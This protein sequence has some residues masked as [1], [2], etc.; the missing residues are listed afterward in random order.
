VIGAG[1]GDGRGALMAGVSDRHRRGAV[2]ALIVLAVWRTRRT[3]ATSRCRADRRCSSGL[4]GAAV[5]RGRGRAGRLERAAA[6]RAHEG[7]EPASAALG[8]SAFSITMAACR[9]AGDRLVLRFGARRMM[10]AGWPRHVRRPDA[11]GAQHAFRAVGAC[12]FALIGWPRR[13]WCR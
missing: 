5:L 13:T 4:L 3:A 9:F 11:G 8:Y 6:D 1:L 7:A 2:R 12:G 10:A